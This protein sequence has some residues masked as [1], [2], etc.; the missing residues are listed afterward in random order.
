MHVT[1]YIVV[2]FAAVIVTV[3]AGLSFGLSGWQTT[4]T[5]GGVLAIGQFAMLGYVAIRAF[6]QDPSSADQRDTHRSDPDYHPPQHSQ[7]RGHHP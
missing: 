1:R 5:V 6:G 4:A 7:Q 2:M 3:V